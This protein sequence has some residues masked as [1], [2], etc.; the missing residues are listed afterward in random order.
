V[1]YAEPAS[2]STFDYPIYATLADSPEKPAWYRPSQLPVTVQRQIVLSPGESLA[3]R[4]LFPK[5]AKL[6]SSQHPEIAALPTEIAP[7]VEA[8]PKGEVAQIDAI[9]V[10]PGRQ[11]RTRLAALWITFLRLAPLGYALAAVVTFVGGCLL[12]AVVESNV[13]FFVATPLAVGLLVFSVYL[14]LLC[15]GVLES[16]WIARRLRQEIAGRAGALIDSADADAICMSLIP[17]AS[18]N[19][20]WVPPADDVMLVKIDATRRLLLMEGDENRYLIPAGAIA[21]CETQC[22]FHRLD[23]RNDSQ[24]WMLRL[25]VRIQQGSREL[26]LQ[27][28]PVR[29]LPGTNGRRRRTAE[30]VLRQ[31]AAIRSAGD[32]EGS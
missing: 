5:L 10:P 4:P 13:V 8:A 21:E 9:T 29:W 22:F 14:W 32:Q 20:F 19:S 23:E 25:A 2:G 27:V 6:L 15:K 3:L 30:A 7:V 17:R 31:I 24:I 28:N 12:A 18:F 26:L 1:E 11:I 16:R